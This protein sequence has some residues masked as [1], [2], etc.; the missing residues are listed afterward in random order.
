MV[1]LP[2]ALR[3]PA[4]VSAIAGVLVGPR[5]VVAERDATGALAWVLDATHPEASA[6]LDGI[7][8]FAPH[9][10]AGVPQPPALAAAVLDPAVPRADPTRAW[11]ADLGATGASLVVVGAGEPLEPLAKCDDYEIVGNATATAAVRRDDRTWTY[12]AVD[13]ARQAKAPL[14]C[15]GPLVYIPRGNRGIASELIVAPRRGAFVDL[16]AATRDA[17][18]AAEARRS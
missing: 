9:W 3:D 6:D 15:A 10:T 17:L 4:L 8:R 12:I 16:E 11:N 18:T 14:R 7:F 1:T 2:A 5:A 13:G